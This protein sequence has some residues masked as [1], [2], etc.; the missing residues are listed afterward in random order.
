MKTAKE[1]RNDFL[2]FFKNND[3]KIVKSTPVVP[4]DDHITFRK[5][6]DEPV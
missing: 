1:I 6:R 3:H 5:C 2:E 4:Q